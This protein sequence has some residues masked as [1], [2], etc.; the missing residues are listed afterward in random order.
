MDA[1]AIVIS[2]AKTAEI[3]RITAPA[4]VR[5]VA[6]RDVRE[7]LR[8]MNVITGMAVPL[9]GTREGITV[10]QAFPAMSPAVVIRNRACVKNQRPAGLPGGL[11]PY[12]FLKKVFQFLHGTCCGLGQHVPCGKKNLIG[13]EYGIKKLKR[14]TYCKP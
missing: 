7:C 8:G 6:L 5:I 3:V 11:L 9:H 12:L 10:T 13:H 4:E 1:P 2:A 14:N